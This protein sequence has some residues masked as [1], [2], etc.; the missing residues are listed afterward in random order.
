M[1][2]NARHT[3]PG[4]A[5]RPD[6]DGLR[7]VAILLVLGF[8]AFPLVIPGGFVG[9]DVFFVISGF[10]ITST[11]L[12]DLNK[13]RFSITEFYGRRF[14]R[15]I[16]ALM[17]MLSSVLILGY[18]FFPGID[19][20][21]LGKHLLAG[22]TFTSNLLLIRESGYFDLS[23]NLKPLL[24]LWSLGIEEQF[25]L[26]W[27][28]LAAFVF[29]KRKNLL[30]WIF[31]L[32]TLSFLS[33]LIRINHH[34][35]STFYLLP[36]RF[37]ELL[38]GCGLAVS[39]NNSAHWMTNKRPKNALALMGLLMV[40]LSGVFFNGQ[41]KFPGAWAALPTL[42]SAFLI[43][44]GTSSWLNRKLLSHPFMVLIGLISYPLYLWHWPLLSSAKI[45]HGTET[46]ST[47]CLL[48][49]LLV[50]LL[51]AYATY[52][53]IEQPFRNYFTLEKKRSLRGSPFLIAV[54]LSLIGVFA[55]I[56]LKMN[57][58]TFL[59]RD[60]SLHKDIRL[61]QKYETYDLREIRDGKCFI[62]VTHGFNGFSEECFGKPRPGSP[63]LF[64]LGDSFAAN[65]YP[66]LRRALS[67]TTVNLVQLTS[68]RC[69]PLLEMSARLKS[70][71]P[72]CIEANRFALHKIQ[73]MKSDS[74]ILFAS[75]V[76]HWDLPG[77]NDWLDL[78]IKELRKAGVKN[79]ILIGTPPQWMP[80]LPKVIEQ[81]FSRPGLPI[82]KMM[83]YGIQPD[84]FK[85][86]LELQSLSKKEKITF[87]SL[88]DELC[89][90][91]GCL[92]R[93]G[94]NISEDLL[95]WDSAH[96]TTHGAEY[97]SR[98]LIKPKLEILLNQSQK[99]PRSHRK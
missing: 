23:A 12:K 86:N 66:G 99:L 72:G 64:L 31:I 40:I 62:D 11:I 69:P 58:E 75:W 1:L 84:I 27:P 13:G 73:E 28:L 16:P 55:F 37:W 10:L 74:V 15:I 95:T 79:I 18:F 38:I 68:S 41:L 47:V 34:P 91:S 48:S 85:T 8:H 52:R 6:I 88:T 36:T 29:R 21:R 61:L 39:E 14:R 70:A 33:N 63:N 49:A 67:E 53:W 24:H 80:T 9:V 30:K 65:L 59:S 50:S 82:P 60:W 2:K 92:A 20:L 77:F 83:G 19:F 78:T 57:N 98:T 56:G 4:V 71:Y 97:V 90:A 94:E 25:Y 32:G 3:P 87:I 54:T 89:N 93:V 46:L 35:V 51:L 5:Y 81:Q 17:T 26:G 76:S 22:A 44:S 45:L 43:V 96:F 42:G 7:A